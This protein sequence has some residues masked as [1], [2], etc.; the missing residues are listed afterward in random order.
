[1]VKIQ[2]DL[3]DKEM[4]ILELLKIHFKLKTKADAIKKLIE[5]NKHKFK[6]EY[7]ED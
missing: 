1:M 3:N 6:I 4:L 5:L 2:L 7:K